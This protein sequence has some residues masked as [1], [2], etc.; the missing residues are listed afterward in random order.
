MQNDGSAWPGVIC[1]VLLAAG[2]WLSEHLSYITG[3]MA[4]VVLF[5]QIVVAWRSCRNEK[6][7]NAI[8]LAELEQVKNGP[9]N[10]TG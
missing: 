9:R 6:I 4:I 2:T 7:K 10:H 5:I 1:H 8:L 3:T